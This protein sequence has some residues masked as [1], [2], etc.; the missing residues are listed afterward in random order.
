MSLNS[1]PTLSQI[2]HVIV[3]ALAVL[4]LIELFGRRFGAVVRVVIEE[5][6]EVLKFARDKK[7][8]SLPPKDPGPPS[9]VVSIGE[10]MS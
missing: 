1:I 3:I 6:Y 10:K 8:A 2:E 9:A 7:L 4:G 5:Y